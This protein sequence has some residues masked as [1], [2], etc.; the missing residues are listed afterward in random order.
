MDAS[1]TSHH[2]A[3]LMRAL[4]LFEAGFVTDASIP[5]Q[6][7]RAEDGDWI[8]QQLKAV[9]GEVNLV[10]IKAPLGDD[11]S[12]GD[13]EDGTARFEAFKQYIADITTLSQVRNDS[14]PR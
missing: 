7:G 14:R 6:C 11:P 5:A 2:F 4:Q 1:A 3:V 10:D 9:I 8:C 13:Q 12:Q